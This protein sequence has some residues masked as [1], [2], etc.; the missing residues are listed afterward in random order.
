[1]A[2]GV[3][4]FGYFLLDKQKKVPRQSGETD[5]INAKTT[6]AILVAVAFL[7]G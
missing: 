2:G 4:F 7:K 1:M 5:K 6:A 3:F